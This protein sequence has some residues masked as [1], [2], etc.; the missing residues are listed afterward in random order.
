M[1]PRF[2]CTH[3]PSLKI[4]LI[5]FKL[6]HRSCAIL[7]STNAT[8]RYGR[9]LTSTAYV[10]LIALSPGGAHPTSGCILVREKE[11]ES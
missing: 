6:A 10:S 5:A 7:P 2:L 1:I 8:G 9:G 3:S 11:D 4:F